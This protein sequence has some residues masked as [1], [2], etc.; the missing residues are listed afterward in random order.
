MS[1]HTKPDIQPA[2]TEI[3]PVPEY[4]LI[5]SSLQMGTRILG[6]LVSVY[7]FL[8]HREF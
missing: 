4:K 2:E 1:L 6:T 8:N 3:L 7:Y 5:K